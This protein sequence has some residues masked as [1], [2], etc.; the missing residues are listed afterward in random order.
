MQTLDYNLPSTKNGGKITGFTYSRSLN[1]LISSWS[2]EVAG[3]TFKAG[4]SINFGNVLTD[5]II[6]NCYKDTSGLWHIEGRD[7]PTHPS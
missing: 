7:A 5:G 4:A 1:E 2:A 3:G 6:T